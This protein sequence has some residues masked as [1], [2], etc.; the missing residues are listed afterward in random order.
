[1]KQEK[2]HI[3][4]FVKRTGRLTV[5]QQRAFENYWQHYGIDESEQPLEWATLFKHEADVILEIGFGNGESLVTQ[6][7]HQPDKN[8]I[9]VEVHVPGLGRCLHR[10]HEEN[11]RNIRLS[12]E[13][14]VMLLKRIPDHSLKGIQIYFPDPWPKKRHHKRRL[15]QPLLLNQLISKCHDR[16]SIHIATD[17]EPYAQ[18]C[19]ET[20]NNHPELTNVAEDGG[21][22]ERPESR[23]IT[24]FEQR[25]WRLGHKSYDLLFVITKSKSHQ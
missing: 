12:G 19:L 20:L 14:V 21:Y 4:S 8:F 5:G 10:C 6:A 15:V 2:R 11:L 25:G 18:H 17:W 1:M 22:I 3:R 13:D 9:G 24:K 16:A 23:P 7:K